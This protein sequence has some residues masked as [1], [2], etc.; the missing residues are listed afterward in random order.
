MP[1]KLNTYVHAVELNDKGEIV[2]QGQFGPDDDLPDW[3]RRSISAPG[4]WEGTDDQD[5]PVEPPVRGRRG[6]RANDE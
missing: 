6:S 1:K 2:N 5:K 3:A 4:V